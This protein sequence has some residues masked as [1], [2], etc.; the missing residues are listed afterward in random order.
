MY[1][2][3]A[4][5]MS[6][7][8]TIRQALR[9]AGFG[10]LVTS[11]P[12]GSND[13]AA[14]DATA[15]PFVVNEELTTVHAHVARANSHWR[16]MDGAGA[17]L[18]V[19]GVDAYVSPRWYPSKRDHGEVVP[20]WNYELIHL[21]GTIEVHHES[22]WKHTHL[23]ALTGAAEHRLE[24]QPGAPWQVEH[25]PEEFVERLIRGI[26]GIEM[27]VSGI[28]AKRKMSQN[29]PEA[30]RLGAADGLGRSDSDRDRAVARLM[31]EAED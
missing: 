11:A 1:I 17:L 7:R 16:T 8:D 18:I 9:S 28:E 24:S 13:G 3:P 12:A 5:S 22:G 31:A 23:R 26:V 25:A 14:P 10:H 30:D 15:L 6:D 2:P 29:R 27:S 4:Y 21:R 19:P 20:T